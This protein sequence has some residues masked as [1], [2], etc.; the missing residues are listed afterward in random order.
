MGL[1][2]CG[3]V[4]TTHPQNRKRRR[5]AMQAQR[6]ISGASKLVSALDVILFVIIYRSLLPI[7]SEGLRLATTNLPLWKGS[8]PSECQIHA[9][10]HYSHDPKYLRIVGFVITEDDGEDDSSKV[11]CRPYDARQDACTQVS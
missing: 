3:V 6:C 7:P 2:S 9:N 4:V 5:R 8:H 10:Y 1:K 11:S